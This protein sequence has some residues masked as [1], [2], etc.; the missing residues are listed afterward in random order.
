MLHS[1]FC[2]LGRT[3][4][5]QVSALRDEKWAILEERA[6]VEHRLTDAKAEAEQLQV[7][8]S[9]HCRPWGAGHGATC[10]FSGDGS[11]LLSTGLVQ[12]PSLSWAC[13]QEN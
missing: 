9:C 12:W 4:A 2:L 1:D 11:G 13:C 7:L 6:D 8:P 5:W 10:V 3:G